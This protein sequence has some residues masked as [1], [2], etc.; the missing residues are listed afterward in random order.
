MTYNP[1]G[2]TQTSQP[3]LLAELGAA[4][5]FANAAQASQR[6]R[7]AEL[8][9]ASRQSTYFGVSLDPLSGYRAIACYFDSD[10]EPTHL[11]AGEVV[12]REFRALRVAPSFPATWTAANVANFAETPPLIAQ[13]LRLRLWM[14][15][16]EISAVSLPAVWS[17]MQRPLT[18][19]AGGITGTDP[20]LLAYAGAAAVVVRAFGSNRN[21]ANANTVTV[22]L[23]G[24]HPDPL[25]GTDGIV[26]ALQRDATV[27]ATFVIPAGADANQP[28][29]ASIGGAGYHE[30]VLIPRVTAGVNTISVG[31][32]AQFFR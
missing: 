23:F 21:T 32:R 14:T 16:P 3:F 26:T 1:L 18:S 20:V 10:E 31:L 15:P 2:R 8:P 27:L 22:D 30:F 19:G 9:Q 17:V 12:R 28:I 13:K 5:L 6:R 11:L 7:S 29:S 25:D 4:A 24:V